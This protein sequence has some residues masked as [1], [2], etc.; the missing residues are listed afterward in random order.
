M[1]KFPVT[2]PGVH[3]D[4]ERDMNSAFLEALALARPDPG[5]G[6]A[7]AHSAALALALLEKV[8]R[9]EHQRQGPASNPGFP[10]DDLLARVNVVSAALLRLQEEDVKAYFSLAKALTAADPEALAPA[11]EEA[12]ACPLRIMQQA[13]DGLVLMAQVG[14]GCGVHLISD[15]LV[16]CE[17]LG[18]AFRGAHHI[19]RANLPLMRR[20]FKRAV[21]V[22]E[23]T[24]TV[25]AIEAELLQVRAE[26][27]RR[28]ACP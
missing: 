11:L 2:A 23:L 24:L 14:A 6:A 18:A 28:Q 21:W 4:Q 5:G 15:V 9:L 22:E 12:V 25:T 16:A 26:L 1:N 20:D 19:A 8:V 17:L 27:L 13:Q 7:A 10:W 3:F